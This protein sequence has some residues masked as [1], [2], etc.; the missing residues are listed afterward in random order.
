MMAKDVLAVIGG[1]CL[2]IIIGVLLAAL[3]EVIGELID[4]AKRNYR[5]KHRF[6]GPPTAKCYCRD[7]T[8]YDNESHKCY[9]FDGWRTAD[10]WFCWDAEPRKKI[11]ED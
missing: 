11:K 6:D 5:I 3:K 10:C 9:K 1:F 4:R 7:C 8:R 2:T